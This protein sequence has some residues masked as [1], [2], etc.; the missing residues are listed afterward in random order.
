MHFF[1]NL[2]KED[3]VDLKKDIF[4]DFYTRLNGVPGG[5]YNSKNTKLQDK[6]K[7]VNDAINGIFV[8]VRDNFVNKREL[9]KDDKPIMALIVQYCYTCLCL[10]ERHKVWPYDFM[11]FSRRIGELWEKF[12]SVAWDFSEVTQRFNAPNFATVKQ[13]IINDITVLSEDS[14]NN[15]EI[16]SIVDSL[17]ELIGDINLKEDEM[18]FY[19]NKRHVIDFKSGFGSNEKGN[20]LRLQAVGNA[21]RKYDPNTSLLLLVRQNINNNYLD[22]LRKGNIWEVHTGNNAYKKIH[23][24]TNINILWVIDNIVDFQNDLTHGFINYLRNENLLSYLEWN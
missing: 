6:S 7:A 22:V 20:M 24:L 3:I 1:Q 18:F 23:D 4:Q 15:I 2:S 9:S 17:L 11:A 5:I 14:K 8:A 12:C 21:Y 19:E 13:G 10:E 16:I